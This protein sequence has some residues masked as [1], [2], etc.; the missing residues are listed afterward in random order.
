MTAPGEPLWEELS[1]REALAVLELQR[2]AARP[3]LFVRVLETLAHSP[4]LLS[5]R[6]VAARVEAA[7]TTA[8]KC[9]EELGELGAVVKERRGRANIWR[10]TPAAAKFLAGR[11]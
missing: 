9:L 7:P 4:A 1:K 8:I 11:R 6:Q 2:M 5:G 3:P 10:P